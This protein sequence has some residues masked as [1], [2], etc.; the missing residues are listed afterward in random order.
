MVLALVGT[1][2]AGCSGS[3]SVRPTAGARSVPSATF[4]TLATPSTS[5]LP[6][7]TFPVMPTSFADVLPTNIPTVPHHTTTTE[8][9]HYTGTAK[10][11]C[12]YLSA[13]QVALIIG[14]NIEAAARNDEKTAKG[15]T[16][17]Y[18]VG[19][20]L[21]YQENWVSL[22]FSAGAG[23]YGYTYVLNQITG[24]KS[25]SGIASKAA[26]GNGTMV[27]L[28]KDDGVAIIMTVMPDYLNDP[29]MAEKIFMAAAHL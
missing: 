17:S 1:L 11:T 9:P 12:P 3:G 24:A 13:D 21:R 29:S 23:S 4:S 19:A 20:D 16:Y 28:T 5:S 7:P 6:S 18:T 8:K 14:V 22:S 10:D 15:C 2:V 26:F 27:V 25:V